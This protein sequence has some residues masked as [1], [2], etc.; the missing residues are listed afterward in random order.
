ML[1]LCVL[2]QKLDT[3]FFFKVLGFL[4]LDRRSK[5]AARLWVSRNEEVV[6][7]QRKG[8]HVRRSFR[9]LV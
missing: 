3:G 2:C 7:S 5:R 4:Y 1:E 6:L 9:R 8:R